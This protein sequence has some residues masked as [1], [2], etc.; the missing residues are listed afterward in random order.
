MARCLCHLSACEVKQIQKQAKPNPHKPMY[1]LRAGACVDLTAPSEAGT[2]W[3]LGDDHDR[4][5]LA[6][7]QAKERP[8]LLLG[9]VF[10]HGTGEHEDEV[11]RPYA[12]AC[13]RQLEGGGHFVCEL[14]SSKVDDLPSAKGLKEDPRVLTV[15]GPQCVWR[16]PGKTGE[17]RW[18]TSWVTSSP[19]I[20]REIRAACS[21]PGLGSRKLHPLNAGAAHQS[22]LTA[23]G[24]TTPTA[25]K[26]AASLGSTGTAWPPHAQ[27][28]GGVWRNATAPG[29]CRMAWRRAATGEGSAHPMRK[30]IRCWP[31]PG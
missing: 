29:Q 12:E 25:L 18:R 13:W 30:C 5:Q 2:Q 14:A 9:S 6:W 7:I 8:A 21:G 17:I 15:D 4:Q 11:V 28:E 31:R 16:V 27:R 20:A 1:G 3:E 24:E 23:N 19:E 26:A 10:S 22:L